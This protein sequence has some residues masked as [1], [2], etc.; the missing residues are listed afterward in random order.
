MEA[1]GGKTITLNE[2]PHTF[3]FTCIE[4]LCEEKS[5][6]I[7]AGDQDE[8]I[9]VELKIKPAKVTLNADPSK[10]YV[11]R[12]KP[13]VPLVANVPVDVPMS[14]KTETL[15]VRELVSGSEIEIT[16]TAGQ[17]TRAT[18]TEAP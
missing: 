2:K 9:D 8:S 18:F 10:S 1:S 12:E 4:D 11:L 13:A 17:P 3:L 14:R 16:V 15:H 6:P 5:R 7:P